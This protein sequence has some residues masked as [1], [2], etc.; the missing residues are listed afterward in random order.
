MAGVF[1]RD[2]ENTKATGA[3]L[4]LAEDRLYRTLQE[5]AEAEALLPSDRRTDFVTIVTRH[6]SRETADGRN[7]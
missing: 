4:Y 5:M 2:W 6:A 1:S 3:Q 7:S